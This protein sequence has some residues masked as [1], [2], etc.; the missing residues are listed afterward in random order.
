[1]AAQGPTTVRCWHSAGLLTSGGSAVSLQQLFRQPGPPN[2]STAEHFRRKDRVTINGKRLAT[3][4]QPPDA[5]PAQSGPPPFGV[6]S[7]SSSSLESCDRRR[8]ACMLRRSCCMSRSTTGLPIL[9]PSKESSSLEGSLFRALGPS[10]MPYF[11][12]RFAC[13]QVRADFRSLQVRADFRTA[14]A[15]G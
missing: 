11:S 10:P 2:Q 9:R 12:R 8:G 7:G 14:V 3:F 6:T 5:R 4:M 15:T 13:L 1:M